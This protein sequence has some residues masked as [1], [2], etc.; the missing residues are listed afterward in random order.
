M[1]SLHW[2]HIPGHVCHILKGNNVSM[3]HL[4]GKPTR[5][6]RITFLASFVLFSSHNLMSS[7]MLAPWFLLVWP[8]SQASHVA[9]DRDTYHHQETKSCCQDIKRWCKKPED[10]NQSPYVLVFLLLAMVLCC[11]C[12]CCYRW[13]QMG[14]PGLK[15]SSKLSWSN[16]M[17]GWLDH[18][19]PRVID[20]PVPEL[21]V[22]LLET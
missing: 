4:Q 15:P 2:R 9:Q 17:T 20:R 14:R 12:C 3:P 18:Q 1:G 19:R 8:W 7:L 5:G 16:P 10:P 6:I 22:Q 21:V 11:C 13:W